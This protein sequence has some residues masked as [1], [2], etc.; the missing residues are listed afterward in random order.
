MESFTDIQCPDKLRAALHKERESG[1]NL[2]SSPKG[3]A[4]L[5]YCQKGILYGRNITGILLHLRMHFVETTT[6][7]RPM[8]WQNTV[9][10][11]HCFGP[12]P[13]HHPLSLRQSLQN[14]ADKCIG[15]PGVATRC[16][17]ESNQHQFSGRNDDYL[18]LLISLGC[19]RI[20]RRMRP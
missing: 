8:L 2:S 6:F 16:G 1:L 10:K 17:S 20:A 14:I 5:I 19:V 15:I 7:T 13:H 18:L 9:L 4:C 12:P 3:Q 11:I